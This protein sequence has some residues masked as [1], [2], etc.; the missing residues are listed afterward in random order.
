MGNGGSATVEVPTAA[1]AAPA[2]D[3]RHPFPA[4]LLCCRP[5]NGE[6][7]QKDTRH[8]EISL[9]GSG[10]EYD[11]GDALGVMPRNCPEL[12]ATLID[13]LG[14]SG[15][16]ILELDG[17]TVTLSE[18]L[19]AHQEITSASESFL[20]ALACRTRDRKLKELQQPELQRK[21]ASL[22]HKMDYVDLLQEYS[23]PPFDLQ[24]FVDLLRPLKHRLYS[25]SSSPM[26]FPRE[27]HLTVGV[28]QY[29]SGN[30]LRK[31]VCSTYL[32]ER[33]LETDS[34]P[35]FVHRNPS[36]RLPRD[37]ARPI[38]MIGPGTGIAPFRAFLQER[39]AV[40]ASGRSWL[41]FGDQHEATDFLYRDEIDAMRRSG[42]LDRVSTAF[43]RDQD[44]KIYV[45]H[46]MLEAADEVYAWLEEGAH[47]YVCGDASRMA[48]DV[49]AALH[50]VVEKAGGFSLE[51][52]ADYV[53]R[54]KREKRYVRDVY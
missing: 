3:R 53:K 33:I 4:R 16:D 44:R 24:T 49:D 9:E 21:R 26:K 54:L 2:F 13:V 38:I 48:K 52:S 29:E 23:P 8:V 41:F 43:S 34:L 19:E 42:V 15:E 5:L 28:V 10:L 35:V 18:A 6:G 7:S 14:A 37:G 22:L 32:S 36:F 40:G 25:I 47:V 17:E 46:R 1:P 31:G 12:V 30:R 51:A 45:Q 27:V 20:K 39:R 11:A 50:R